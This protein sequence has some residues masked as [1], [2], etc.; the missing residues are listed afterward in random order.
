MITKEGVTHEKIIFHAI[1]KGI[2]IS[3]INQR[4]V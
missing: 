1:E 3:P 4:D 2:N